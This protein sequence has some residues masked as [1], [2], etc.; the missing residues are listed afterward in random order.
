M[1]GKTTLKLLTQTNENRSSQT[2]QIHLDKFVNTLKCFTL[3]RRGNIDEG[4]QFQSSPTKRINKNK[5]LVAYSIRIS[6]RMCMTL[7]RKF[8]AVG[9]RKRGGMQ[10]VHLKRAVG[11]HL[12]RK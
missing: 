12:D 3:Q 2:S 9:L 7:N 5:M 10:L 1:R 4:R 8:E 11:K 6:E